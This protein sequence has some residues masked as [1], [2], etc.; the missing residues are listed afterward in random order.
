VDPCDF[1]RDDWAAA[2]CVSIPEDRRPFVY[3]IRY[4]LSVHLVL[5]RLGRHSVFRESFFC[6]VDYVLDFWACLLF[7]VGSP[8]LQAKQR[9][10][11]GFE[12]SVSLLCTMESGPNVS[13]GNAPG[14]GK[15]ADLVP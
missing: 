9:R 11:S 10:L 3:C 6:F 4:F 13:V 14:A 8:A 2:S 15:G 12:R 7:T 5:S 1:A